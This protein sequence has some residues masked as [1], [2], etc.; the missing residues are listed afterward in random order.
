MWNLAATL[1]ISNILCQNGILT[2]NLYRLIFFILYYLHHIIISLV[3][4]FSISNYIHPVLRNI[5]ECHSACNILNLGPPPWLAAPG[6]VVACSGGSICMEIML[7]I[8]NAFA[9]PSSTHR[10]GSPENGNQCQQMH[11]DL[12][13]GSN[14]LVLL[15]LEPLRRSGHTANSPPPSPMTCC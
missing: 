4:P 11:K 9:I 8:F 1:S 10:N 5:C 15:F 14:H 12:L 7:M 2:W 13:G 6:L 3:I